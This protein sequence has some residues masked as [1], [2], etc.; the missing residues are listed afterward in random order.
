MAPVVAGIGGAMQMRRRR[1]TLAVLTLLLVGSIAFG[2][3]PQSPAD[4]VTREN[5]DRIA[6]LSIQH[7]AAIFFVLGGAG[8]TEF[9]NLTD[10][11][12]VALRGKVSAEAG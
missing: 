1:G 6:K 2:P 5:Y 12:V 4:Q 9:A 10:A 11:A 3:W 8:V 7:S